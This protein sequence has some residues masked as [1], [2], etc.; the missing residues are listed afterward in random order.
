MARDLLQNSTIL[1]Q[2][3]LNTTHAFLFNTKNDLPGVSL[4]HVDDFWIAGHDSFVKDVIDKI[5]TIFTLGSIIEILHKYLGLVMKLLTSGSGHGLLSRLSSLIE[6]TSNKE[7]FLSEEEV[8]ALRGIIGKL[9]WPAKQARPDICFKLSELASLTHKATVSVALSANKLVRRVN[10]GPSIT[11]RYPTFDQLSKTEL[12]CFSDASLNSYSD[13]STH[14][15]FIIFVAETNTNKSA[16]SAW[17]SAKLRRVARSTLAA[18]CVSLIECL[19]T[20]EFCR[21][22]RDRDT[23]R[24]LH[25]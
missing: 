8:T 2:H 7:R 10:S 17:T 9:L 12:V 24:V 4:T 23:Y 5:R 16:V 11:L 21:N 18:E 25:G 6:D 1:N 15:G 20:A 13:G 22:I 14:A 19:E 3:N